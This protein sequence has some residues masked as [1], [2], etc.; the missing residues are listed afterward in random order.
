MLT[1]YRVL[2]RA[3]AD[4]TQWELAKRLERLQLFI[5]KIETGDLRLDVIE[6]LQITTALKVDPE[7][8]IR[9]VLSV[10][11]QN[12]WHCGLRKLAEHWPHCSDRH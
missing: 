10:R 1:Q 2:A 7:P 6:F 8:I 9:I 4:V 12:I 3:T 5:S 11:G